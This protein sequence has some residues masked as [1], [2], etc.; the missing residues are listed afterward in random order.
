MN[1][2][3]GVDSIK[4]ALL[5]AVKDADRGIFGMQVMRTS[6]QGCELR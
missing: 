6:P 4:A 1:G 5:D 2:T 3:C